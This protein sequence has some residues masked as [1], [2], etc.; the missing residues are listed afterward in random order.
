MMK[1]LRDKE[2]FAATSFLIFWACVAARRGGFH[3]LARVRLWLWISAALR[4]AQTTAALCEPRILCR[5]R[6]TGA[7]RTV[8]SLAITGGGGQAHSN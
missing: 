7:E 8:F 2:I 6:R 3:P 4:A 1:S 5:R